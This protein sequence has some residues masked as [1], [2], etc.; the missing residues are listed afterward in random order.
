[1]RRH[2]VLNSENF[3]LSREVEKGYEQIINDSAVKQALQFIQ[4][5]HDQTTKDQIKITEIPAPTFHEK[6]RGMYFMDRLKEFSLEDIK[7]D[8]VGN[9]YG[10]RKGTGNGP[11]IF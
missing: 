1:M 6:E 2:N 4:K 9:V 7:M 3:I 11:K 10:V 8:D 5:D